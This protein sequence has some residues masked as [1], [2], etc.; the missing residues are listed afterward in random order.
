MNVVKLI[1]FAVVAMAALVSAQ[2]R[3]NIVFILS[4]DVGYGDVGCYGA[5]LVKTPNIDRLA[6]HGVRFTDGH[7][8]SATCTPSRYSIMTGQYAFRK[9]GTNVLPGDANLTITPGSKTLPQ[10]LHDAGY[11]TGA[12]GKWHLGLGNGKI[13]WN[14]EIKPG[15]LEC[16]FDSCFII[17]ATGDR[18][19]CV[20]VENHRVAGLDPNDPILVS[21]QR[22]VGSEPTGK[23]NPELL[24]VHPS[25]GHDGTIVNGIS[26]IGWMSGGHSARWIDELIAQTLTRQAT[27][28]IEKNRDKTFFLY[29][30]T[31]DIHV[32][33]W[34]HKDFVGTSGCGIRGDAIQQLDWSVGQ[35]MQ[36]LDRLG[37]TDN[38]LVIFSSD[39]GPVVDDGYADGA[40]QKLDGHKPAGP[41]RGGKYSIYEGGTRIPLITSWPARIKPGV[42]DALVCQIDFAASFAALAA[43]RL[44]TDAVP[45]SFNVLPALLGES[46]SGRETLVEQSAQLGIRKGDWKLVSRP[47]RGSTGAELYDLSKDIGETRNV[48]AEHPQIATELL[49]LLEKIRRDGRSRPGQ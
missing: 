27:Q 49:D 37:L 48:A 33:R 23:E 43:Q 38:T 18:V 41:L 12:V 10:I 45:D 8:A 32:P 13:D 1:V 4:D 21:Y 35:V 36:T 3:P 26:R 17:P 14:A 2:S 24:K 47:A 25:Q 22:K 29:F 16:G 5:T 6:A 30:A 9:R 7:C 46:K 11:T 44:P 34:P 40:V 31:H 28:F 42:S 20:F 19:P 15:P 39:N